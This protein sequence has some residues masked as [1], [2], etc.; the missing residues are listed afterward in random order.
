MWPERG[1]EFL[2]SPLGRKHCLNQSEPRHGED[3]RQKLK[4]VGNNIGYEV[5]M[6]LE[7]RL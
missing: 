1:T 2:D 4:H 5:E 7:S 6:V 3:K